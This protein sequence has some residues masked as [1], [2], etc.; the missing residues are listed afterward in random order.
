MDL[1]KLYSRPSGA[2]LGDTFA[3]WQA[4]L[5]DTFPVITDASWVSTRSRW[6]GSPE[7]PSG[8]A[9]VRSVESNVVR[10]PV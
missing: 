9:V 2:W 3:D 6:P 7:H 5:Q 8:R 10:T 4:L 1:R